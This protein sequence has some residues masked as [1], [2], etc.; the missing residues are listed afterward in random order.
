MK[1][2]DRIIGTLEGTK[3]GF[4]NYPLTIISLVIVYILSI[5]L[6]EDVFLNENL[7][8][9]LQLS[10]ILFVPISLIIKETKKNYNYKKYMEYIIN[11]LSLAIIV[12]YYN[13]R[14]ENFIEMDYIRFIGLNIFFYLVYFY[15]KKI[16]NDKYSKYIIK[17]IGD[18][19]ISGIF[20]LVLFLGLVFILITINSLFDLDINYKYYLY[21]FLFIGVIFF[22]LLTL[23]KFS[24]DIE[25]DKYIFPK[26][27][28]NLILYIIMPLSLVYILI[29]YLYF[30]KILIARAIPRGI[31][32]HLVLWY[33]IIV[34][35]VLF[36][37][38]PIKSEN[39]YLKLYRRI[40]P[41]IILPILIMMFISMG[42][43]INQYGLTENRYF[44]VIMGIWIVVTDLYIVFKEDY[45]SRL[46]PILLSIT[47]FISMVGPLNSF[48]I[49]KK[50]QK[51]RY[52]KILEN[53][54]MLVEGEIVASENISKEDRIN[55]SDIVDYFIQRDSK[56]ELYL[57]KNFTLTSM[58]KVFGFEYI[59]HYNG[60]GGNYDYIDLKEEDIIELDGYQ[61][62]V[63][64]GS[65]FPKE[66]YLDDMKVVYDISENI[67]S[68]Y[69]ADLII[70]EKD[71]NEEVLNLIE[72]DKDS[73]NTNMLEQKNLTIVDEE[74]NIR[75]KILIKHL[76]LYNDKIENIEFDLLFKFK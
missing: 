67:L 46:I 70:Y 12:L 1:I 75:A 10:F 68:I 39:N 21:T 74:E 34:M 23:S 73:K 55:I 30:I 65:Y 62:L 2:K 72:E 76:G 40:L 11:L 56:E 14:Y 51:N 17:S 32:S 44:V 3:D 69:R 38:R 45:N 19:F 49:S 15:M 6:L 4:K 37:I 57:D 50:S 25:Y 8:N 58:N 27:F 22:P 33:S 53:N 20:G 24:E 13:Y 48:Y 9:V 63:R 18:M 47:I 29:L 64:K 61:Y 52:T 43:R 42:I 5:I 28:K 36:F 66:T 16:E 60:Y 7:I 41:I 31:V 35:G 59:N 71:L 54:N 26:A